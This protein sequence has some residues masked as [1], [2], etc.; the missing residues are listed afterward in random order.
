MNNEFTRFK[1]RD[2]EACFAR[3][4]WSGMQIPDKWR[5]V[6]IGQKTLRVGGY[7]F[8]SDQFVDSSDGTPLVKRAT[9][10]NKRAS[11]QGTTEDFDDKY[12]VKN[13]DIL[14]SMDGNF[15]PYFWQNGKAALNQRVCKISPQ[16]G[17]N[18]RFLSYLLKP[19][20]LQTEAS[21]G[22]TTVKSF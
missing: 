1:L 15:R 4:V 16:E 3:P 2:S 18:D 6:N 19:L 11:E 7:G 22:A 9:V 13:G 12:E 5:V 20:L 17:M 14:V 21:T 8:S 10:N